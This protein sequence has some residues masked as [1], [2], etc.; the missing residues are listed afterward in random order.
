[1]IAKIEGECIGVGESVFEN[2]AY[3]YFEVLQLGD[4]R[5]ASEIIRVSGSGVK[6][7][8]KV[9]LTARVFVSDNGDLKVKKIDDE[10][11]PVGKK[12]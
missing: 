11:L 12:I 6:K 2:K 10:P 1:M 7:G 4:G 5:R 3:P 9:F 8:D